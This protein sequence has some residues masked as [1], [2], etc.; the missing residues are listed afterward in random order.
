MTNDGTIPE[1]LTFDNM[2]LL[3]GRSSDARYHSILGVEIGVAFTVSAIMFSIYANLSS[4]GRLHGG[5]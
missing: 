2:M 1:I 4:K 3:P 5:M